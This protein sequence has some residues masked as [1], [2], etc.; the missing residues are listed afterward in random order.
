VIADVCEYLGW[1]DGI[2]DR[3]MGD[4]L[5]LLHSEVSEA[6]EAYRDHGYDDATLGEP[7]TVTELSGHETQVGIPKP[8]GVGAELADVIIRLLDTYHR[9]ELVG[10][11]R[12]WRIA[13]DD[14]PPGYAYGMTFGDW[15]T[16]LHFLIAT[17]QFAQVLPYIA[18]VARQA[19][20]DLF[21]EVERKIA[22]NVTRGYRHGGK[23]L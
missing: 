19:N 2:E 1:Y 16:H 18:G 9:R 15:M 10:R 20:V 8:E 6:L 12:W 17:R 7:I 4:D 11:P 3:T 23:R 13:L 21:A 22:Y 5:A 14:V